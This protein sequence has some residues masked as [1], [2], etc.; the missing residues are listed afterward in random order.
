MSNTNNWYCNFSEFHFN[1]NGSSFTCKRP[2]KIKCSELENLTIALLWETGLDFN[3]SGEDFCLSNYECATPIYNCN[4]GYE[5]WVSYSDANS[6][7][8]GNEVTIYGRIPNKEELKEINKY[9]EE[10]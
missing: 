1:E 10:C 3:L 6:W 8:N 7:K 5:Y 9:M 2:E 4:N